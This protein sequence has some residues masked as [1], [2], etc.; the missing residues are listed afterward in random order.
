MYLYKKT[1]TGSKGENLTMYFMRNST[2]KITQKGIKL[3]GLKGRVKIC[4]RSANST[5]QIMVLILNKVDFRVIF[6]FPLSPSHLI[7]S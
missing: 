3:K 2:L 4:Q 1:Q 5:E 7:S 6:N